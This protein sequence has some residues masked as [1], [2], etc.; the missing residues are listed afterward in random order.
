MD[1]SLDFRR[2]VWGAFS[3]LEIA[4]VHAQSPILIKYEI[5]VKV[6]KSCT[7]LNTSRAARVFWSNGDVEWG[8]E[9]RAKL[10]GNV[11]WET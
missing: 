7:F 10:S 11:E 2:S 9:Q 8:S 4:V 5:I 6:N 3:F 1:E